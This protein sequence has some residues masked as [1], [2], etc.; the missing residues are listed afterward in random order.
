MDREMERVP[1]ELNE[2]TIQRNKDAANRAM[3]R[4]KEY[5]ERRGITPADVVEQ[6]KTRPAAGMRERMIP[7]AGRKWTGEIPITHDSEI[8]DFGSEMTQFDPLK[9]DAETVQDLEMPRYSLRSFMGDKGKLTSKTNPRRKNL[10]E[11]LDEMAER[12]M[13]DRGYL[14]WGAVDNAIARREEEELE[15]ED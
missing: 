11:L 6:Y 4:N 15:D 12:R 13:M 8:P 2:E 5:N 9:V 14:S 10:N 1:G 7:I 3:E